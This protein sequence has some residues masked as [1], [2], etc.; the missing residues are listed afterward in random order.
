MLPILLCNM[1]SFCCDYI[2]RQKVGGTCLSYGYVKQFPVLTDNQYS[3]QLFQFI[4]SRFIELSFTSYSVIN[5]NNT[6][7]NGPPFI[8][9]EER[10]FEIQCELDAL[11]FHLYLGT[12]QEWEKNHNSTSQDFSASASDNTINPLLAYFKTPRKA[13]EY[14]MET[15]PIVKRKDEAK[16]GEYRTKLRI[17]AI[18][19]QM[20]PLF[21]GSSDKITIST[22]ISA[23][24]PPPGPPCD[25]NGNFIPSEKWDPNSWFPHIHKSK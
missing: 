8:W 3:A 22:Y 9:D 4:I 23:L 14:I 18:Y 6:I 24:N 10:R 16:F 17:L 12:Q 21:D 7:Y 20:T 5:N 13:V 1:N 15:F 25:E 19:D 11:Y 2:I